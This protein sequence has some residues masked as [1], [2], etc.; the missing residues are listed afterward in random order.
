MTKLTEEQWLEQ[1]VLPRIKF[2]DSEDGCWEWSGAKTWGY[3]VVWDPFRR[4]MSRATRI[5]W[6]LAHGPIPPKFFACHRCD[7]PSCCRLSHLFLGTQTHNMAD[8]V[9]KGRMTHGADIKWV[10]LKAEDIPAIRQA[11]A[12]GR[13]FQS[14]GDEFGVSKATIRD[15]VVGNSWKHVA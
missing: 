8:A 6:Q 3:G 5:V 1:R 11:R 13:T 10:V 4:R 14:I 7:N 9:R 15:V 12:D 2:D